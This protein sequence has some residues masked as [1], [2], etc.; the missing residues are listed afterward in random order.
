MIHLKIIGGTHFVTTI[1]KTVVTNFNC[2][3]N[4]RRKRGRKGGR[5]GRGRRRQT[6]KGREG[7]GKE[8]KGSF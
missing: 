4:W 2:Y 1:S 8:R 5:E 7:I 6:G 3:I